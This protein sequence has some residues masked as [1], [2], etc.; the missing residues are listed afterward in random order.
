MLRAS[1]VFPTEG[2]AAMI[3]RV[4][5]WKPAVGVEVGEAAAHSRCQVRVFV[6]LL[7]AFPGFAKGIA[8][9]HRLVSGALVRQSHDLGAGGVQGFVDVEPAVAPEAFYHPPGRQ[10]TP[11][12]RGL[13]HQTRVALDVGRDATAGLQ[14]GEVISAPDSLQQAKLLELAVEGEDV[15]RLA[16][17]VKLVGG[18]VDVGMLG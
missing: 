15:D 9:A 10:Q 14:A 18:P 8:Q 17:F 7:E 1:D 12:N 3:V 16:A 11:A 13:L 4:P 6:Q 5:G 2:R